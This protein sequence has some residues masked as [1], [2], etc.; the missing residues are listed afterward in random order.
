MAKAIKKTSIPKKVTTVQK[1]EE[2]NDIC[3]V[4]MPFGK[5]FDNYYTDIYKPAI[6]NSGLIPKRADD[7]YRPS[8][9]VQDIWAYTKQSKIVLADLTDKNPNVFYELGLAHALAK[10]AILITSDISDVPFDLRALRVLDYDKNNPNWGI[11]LKEKIENAIRETLESPITS[12]LPAFLDLHEIEKTKISI[13]EKDFLEL[14]RD[15]EL[16]RNQVRHNSRN[17]VIEIPPDEAK[18]MIQSL[19]DR[20]YPIEDI[21]IRLQQLGV[22]EQWVRRRYEIFMQDRLQQ[23]LDLNEE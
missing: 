23:K 8:S 15:I 12:V 21:V 20:N 6:I 11:I 10:P 14:R 2:H 19:I 7:L 17:K 9:I 4:M 16:M 13:S 5:W 1:K 18:S 3:F 22:P